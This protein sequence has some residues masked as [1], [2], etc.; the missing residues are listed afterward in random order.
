MISER[1]YLETFSFKTIDGGSM[2]KIEFKKCESKLNRIAGT[3]ASTV[4]YT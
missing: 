4:S 2:L 1:N 3:G